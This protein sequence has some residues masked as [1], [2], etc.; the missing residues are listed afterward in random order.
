MD[1]Y[2]MLRETSRLSW[3]KYLMDVEKHLSRDRSDS[4]KIMPID[5]RASKISVTSFRDC[6][7]H[8]CNFYFY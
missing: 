2:D 5:I 6:K 8:N 4:S 3:D 1:V 7:F